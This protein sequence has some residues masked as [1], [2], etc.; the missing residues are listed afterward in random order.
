MNLRLAS[1]A[2]EQIRETL[3]RNQRIATLIENALPGSL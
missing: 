2:E 3:V 1:A